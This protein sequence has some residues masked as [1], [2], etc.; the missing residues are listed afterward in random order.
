VLFCAATDI[1]I[2]V[3]CVVYPLGSRHHSTTNGD[4]KD[5]TDSYN[6]VTDWIK[7]AD[8]RSRVSHLLQYVYLFT[9]RQPP[10]SQGLFIVGLHD[11]SDT[12]LD[13]TPLD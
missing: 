11:H 3:Q 4:G 2:S 12:T 13:R 9:V 6:Y 7:R 1:T 10:V 5:M 8:K